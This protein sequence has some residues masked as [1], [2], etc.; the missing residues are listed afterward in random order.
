MMMLLR[1]FF[2]LLLDLPLFDICNVE[3]PI[4]GFAIRQYYI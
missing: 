1:S 2:P 3:L 4:I